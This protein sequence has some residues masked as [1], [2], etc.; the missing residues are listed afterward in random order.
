MRCPTDA[1]VKIASSSAHAPAAGVTQPSG[2]RLRGMLCRW[3]I[4]AQRPPGRRAQPTSTVES[5][6]QPIIIK[7]LKSV[8]HPTKTL[9]A[10]AF[11]KTY[12][13]MQNACAWLGSF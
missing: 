2:T 1:A 3:Q 13:S 10:C 8:L 11:K 9:V 12:R 6:F 7:N 5:R 4:Y